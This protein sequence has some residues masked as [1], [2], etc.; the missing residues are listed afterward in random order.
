MKNYKELLALLK[1][2]QKTKVWK[3]ISGDQI[4]RIQGYKKPTYVAILGQAKVCN[5]INIYIGKEE[6]YGQYDTLYGD[7]YK[8]PDMYYR[9][10]CYKLVVEDGK[11]ILTPDHKAF[12]KK[13]HLKTDQV[14]MRFERGKL[15]RIITEEEALFLIPI[16]KDIIKISEYINND[17]IQFSETIELDKQLTFSVKETVT[18]KFQKFQTGHTISVKEEKINEDI[19]NKVLIFS[20]KGTF[21]LGLFYGPFYNKEEESY[22]RLLII[23]DLDTGRVLDMQAIAQKDEVNLVNYV[24]E[25]FLKIQRYPQNIAF[26]STEAFLG[27]QTLIGELKMNYKVDIELEPLFEQWKEVRNYMSK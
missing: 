19:L 17:H 15:P 6:L 18:H 3:K 5:E 12:L 9:I 13:N 16:L 2:Y 1:I 25:S 23:S 27:C 4:F 11:E 24:L 8:H 10:S 22:N 20:Q 7:Y 26:T 14:I 21:G